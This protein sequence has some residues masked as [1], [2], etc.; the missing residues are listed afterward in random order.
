MTTIK[1]LSTSGATIPDGLHWLEQLVESY[2]KALL[3]EPFYDVV[4]AARNI[5]D[6][7]WARQLAH[8]S[9]EFPFV[10]AM[11]RDNFFDHPRAT[12]LRKFFSEH[13]EEESGHY[14]MLCEWL[15]VWGLL[16]DDESPIDTPSSLA[17]RA[18]L[19]HGYLVVSI[20]SSAATIVTLNVAT[21]A[22]SHDFF[23]AMKPILDRFGADSH[24]WELHR[25]ADEFHSADGLA[26]LPECDPESR[27]GRELA[28]WA[29]EACAFWGFMLN[30]WVGVDRWPHLPTE[31]SR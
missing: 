5:E 28:Q 7:S 13:V 17:T 6:L 1:Q 31:V 4:T 2:R 20:G 22:A 10:L 24:Y 19:G 15:A 9:Y 30:S 11:R 8:H 12:H 16:K 18:C 25:T 21:E 26:H 14:D 23:T 29:Y 27:Q 3:A